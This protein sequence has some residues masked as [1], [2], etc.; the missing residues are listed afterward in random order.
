MRS[1]PAGFGDAL[2]G[3]ANGL[4]STDIN[5][6]YLGIS[7][8][9]LLAALGVISVGSQGDWLEFHVGRLEVLLGPRTLQVHPVSD[10]LCK[11]LLNPRGAT[12]QPEIGR[13]EGSGSPKL[14]W[15]HP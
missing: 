14:P 3:V 11:E 1:L 8:R 2:A 9:Q 5:D 7:K 13:G 12:D 15:P 6:A 4:P 10:M